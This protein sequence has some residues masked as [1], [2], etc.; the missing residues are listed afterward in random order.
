MPNEIVVVTNSCVKESTE[1]AKKYIQARNIPKENL[2]QTNL[3][4]IETIERSD[5]NNKLVK[6]LRQFIANLKNNSQIRCLLL[7]YGMPL[8]VAAPARTMGRT[9][10]LKQI[11]EIQIKAKPYLTSGRAALD[12]ELM[13]LMVNKYPLAGWLANPFFAAFQDKKKLNDREKIMLVSRLDGPDP[14]AVMRILTDTLAAEK[15]GLKGRAYFDARW[16]GKFRSVKS[17]YELYDQAIHLA[18]RQIKKI[19]CMPVIL[20]DNETLFHS[21]CC[22]QA[23]LYCGWYS[24]AKYIPAFS[25]QKGAIGYHIASAECSTLHEKKSQVWCKRMIEEGVAAT[26]GPVEEP[27]IEAFPLPNLFFSFLAEGKLALAE[28]YLLSLPYLSWKMV[29]IGDPLYRPFST[30]HQLK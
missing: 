20:D 10:G 14:K 21:G 11:N 8:K 4:R 19:D 23:A 25:W 2:F 22:P 24:L 12:S 5:Y 27:Y 7:M 3:G 13:L 28:C 16:P 29:L 30:F 18:A 9:D 1:L 26:L 17:G 6:P 15:T